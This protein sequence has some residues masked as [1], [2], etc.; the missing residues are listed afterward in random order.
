MPPN[1]T[2][3]PI[4]R[5]SRRFSAAH[6]PLPVYL[7]I[8][9]E[10]R[11]DRTS[12]YAL[13]VHDG[14]Y[15]TDY[16]EGDL[17]THDTSKTTK[18]VIIE[19]FTKLHGV[20][21]LYAMAQNYKVQLVAC[22]YDIAKGFLQGD[23]D[24]VDL[25]ECSTMTDYWKDLDAIPFRVQTHGI[26]PDERASAAVRKAV[27]WLSPKYPGNL[28]RISV[29]YRHE[30]CFFILSKFNIILTFIVFCAT[31]FSEL[32]SFRSKVW[33]IWLVF[34]MWKINIEKSYHFLATCL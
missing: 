23:E 16:Y 28:P 2:R 4:R 20:V 32:G 19:A 24:F 25:E 6:V 29:G 15:S 34:I 26:S 9:V 33:Y 3:A 22:S 8:D 31:L 12:Y 17:M 11:D 18:E 10:I 1:P 21:E 27:M 30:V 14:M 5:T 7:G 13:S